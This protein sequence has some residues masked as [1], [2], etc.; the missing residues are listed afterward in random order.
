MCKWI[1]VEDRLPM[2]IEPVLVYIDAGEHGFQ[3]TGFMYPNKKWTWHKNAIIYPSAKVTH[4]MPLPSV[5]G[6]NAPEGDENDA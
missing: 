5:P 2:P 6:I 4:W 1:S 3:S